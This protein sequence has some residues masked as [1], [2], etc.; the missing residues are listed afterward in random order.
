MLAPI[1]HESGDLPMDEGHIVRLLWT[2]HLGLYT[3]LFQGVG[4]AVQRLTRPLLHK[5]WD[6][7]LAFGVHYCNYCER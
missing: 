5:T 1:F 2:C 7:F 4:S 3:N 6:S